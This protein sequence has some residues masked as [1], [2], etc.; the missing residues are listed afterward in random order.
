MVVSFLGLVA[1]VV[2]L[3]CLGLDSAAS[4]SCNRLCL[5]VSPMQEGPAFDAAR[6]RLEE[7]DHCCRGEKR[8]VDGTA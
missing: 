7:C 1:S 8:L 3:E 5:T 6:H 2:F 4:I